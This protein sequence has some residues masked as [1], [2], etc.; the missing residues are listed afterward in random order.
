M[1]RNPEGSAVVTRFHV[2]LLAV[3]VGAGVPHA[4]AEDADVARLNCQVISAAG[5]DCAAS[6]LLRL[7]RENEMLRRRLAELEAA[8]EHR[9][10]GSFTVSALDR[11]LRFLA[12]EAR[13]AAASWRHS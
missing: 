6:G 9:P 2:A 7:E 5:G 8:G 11:A 1:S 12:D 13:R 3:L 10:L 4:A